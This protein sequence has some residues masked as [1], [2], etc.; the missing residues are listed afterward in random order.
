MMKIIVNTK[1]KILRAGTLGFPCAIGKNGAVAACDGREGDGKTP[2]GTYTP[3]YGL[4]RTDRVSLPE[5]KLVFW[6]IRREDGWCDEPQ[7]PAYNRPV[8]LPYPSSAEKLWRESSV[9]DIIIA[10]SHNDSPPISGLG[11][12]IFLHIARDGYTPTQ[13]CIAV[14]MA[15]L[16]TFLPHIDAQTPIEIV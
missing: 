11:S 10:L 6:P 7:D 4:Y 8:R 5:T 13:G 16:L 9:Y 3:R 2:L 14:D 12:A 15:T 1:Q